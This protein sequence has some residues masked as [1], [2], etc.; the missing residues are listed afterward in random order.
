[1]T[2]PRAWP[3]TLLLGVVAAVFFGSFVGYGFN[4]EDEGNILYQI[5]RTFR[6]DRP[7]LD[8]HT[9]YT[10]AVFYLNA[11]LFDWFG[12]SVV[13]LR[14]VL[15]AVNAASVVMI[16]RLALRF[17]PPLE[18]AAAALV[19]AIYL[20]FYA[21]QFASFNIPYP[22]WYAVLAWLATQ[23]A[24]MKAV[25]QGSRRWLGIAGV[26]A[27]LAFSF[28]PNTGILALGSV[29]L[30]QLLMTAPLRGRIGALLEGLLLLVAF[31]AVFAVL[32]FDVFTEHFFL[33]GFPL[34]LVI[35]GGFWLRLG[36][37]QNFPSLAR[38]SIG[39]GFADV[40]AIL[41]GF[42]L[43]T[44]LWLAYFLPRLGIGRFAE[45]VLLLGA[46]VERIYLI[47]YPD[48]SAWSGALMAGLVLLWGIAFLLGAGVLRRR[49]ILAL[50][51]VLSL[52]LLGA[53]AIFGLA[54]E[55]LLLSI[56]MQLEN[57][58][59]FLIP[60]LLLVATLM[61]LERMSHPL[62]WFTGQ[63]RLSLARVT[64]ALVFGLMLFLQLYPRIDFMH[65]VVAM[66]SALV[67]AAAALW[68]FEVWA[69]R[70]LVST[71]G[72]LSPARIR[73]LVLL[74]IVLGLFS[75]AAP[76]VDARLAFDPWP[77]GRET[78]LLQQSPLPVGLEKDRDHDLRELQEVATFVEL[79]TKPQEEIFVFP[80]LAIVPFV[81][82]RRTP[83]PHDYFFPGRPSHADEADMV[84]E[85]EADPP[86]LVVSLNDRL[87]Y[88]SASPAYY[89]ILRDYIQE[90]YDRVRRIGRYDILARKELR[91]A[92]P[93]WA[94]PE[95]APGAATTFAAGDFHDV[96]LETQRIGADGSSA[97]LAPWGHRLADVDRG[98]RG[99]IIAATV[100]VARREPGGL[101]AVAEAMVDGR[102]EQL[103]LIRAMGEYA[104]PEVLLYLQDVFLS[105]SGRLRWESARS[106]NYVLA[107]R[108]SD[109]FRLAGDREGP[110][111][112]LPDSFR[113][114]EM[115][116]MLDDFV[117]RQRIGAFAAIAAAEEGRPDLIPELEYFE[118]EE[119]TTWWRM[120]AAY[121]LVQMGA[122]EHLGTLFD[123]LNTGTL[124]G[125]Y[126]PSLLLDEELVDSELVANQI[127]EELREGTEEERETA[128]WVAAY[129][130]R[131]DLTMEL[132]AASSD[133]SPAVRRAARWAL[134]KRRSTEQG[135]ETGPRETIRRQGERS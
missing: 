91:L 51:A 64:I 62:A 123:A 49:A 35:G 73:L 120:I 125:H 7:Y 89:F 69:A 24:M 106:I 38:R 81:T 121:S 102:R 135:V 128:A 27:G 43:I 83:L 96:L 25:E 130:S 87:G 19:Y 134:E 3:Q 8:F 40:G 93:A 105:S 76:F 103:L 9:G 36:V 98:V 72:W 46:G 13:P 54:P 85:L 65:V 101:A 63:V 52:S 60:A 22:A 82:D 1:M 99:A 34:L 80:A 126:V 10:P 124:A 47:Y 67:L 45:E 2:A 59:F 74:P 131:A 116:A 68:R 86:A 30:C 79:W 14:L 114:D 108:L 117:E 94:V 88:F 20:P 58:S 133:S 26:G 107:R 12:V 78:T 11:W 66:P 39:A 112:D 77:E 118:D 48:I 53:L 21:G 111:W 56:A 15:V 71:A 122:Q 113:T 75:R 6:G 97:D 119:E 104:G 95:S 33:L 37:R 132:E 42:L 23:L 84:A 70:S 55:G 90:N 115:V 50:A 18:S 44:M 32:T 4:L 31:G 5:L 29:V 28:K 110:L 57:L 109:R 92:N 100:Q 129:V 41:G 17:A 127:R 61:W 16:F